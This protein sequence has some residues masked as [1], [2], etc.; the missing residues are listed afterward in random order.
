MASRLSVIFYILLCL[1]L[2]LALVILPW[3]QPFGSDWGS[4]FFLLYAVNKTGWQWLQTAVASGWARGAVTGLGALNIFLA[5]R[6]IF[7]FRQSARSLE[8]PAGDALR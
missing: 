8:D 4:N 6:E 5:F 1:E 3:Y 2:G 7:N